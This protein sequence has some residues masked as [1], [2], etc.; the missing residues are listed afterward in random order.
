MVT[1][2]KVVGRKRFR[3]G[4]VGALSVSVGKGGGG[5]AVVGE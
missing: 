5:I 4:N 1:L 2:S 3:N